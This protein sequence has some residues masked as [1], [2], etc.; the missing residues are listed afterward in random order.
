MKLKE[1]CLALL[2]TAVMLLT[3]MPAMA[4]AGDTQ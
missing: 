3:F 1:R 2:L 4:F